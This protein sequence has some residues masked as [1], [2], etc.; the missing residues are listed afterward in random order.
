MHET[1]RPVTSHDID[2]VVGLSLLAWAVVLAV[3]AI[4]P[5]F[6]A[7]WLEECQDPSSAG[8]NGQHRRPRAGSACSAPPSGCRGRMRCA[9][10]SWAASGASARTTASSS[11]SATCGAFRGNTWRTSTETGRTKVWRNAYP[12]RRQHRSRAWRRAARCAR[13]R[14]SVASITPM[15]EQRNAT[16]IDFSASTAVRNLTQP[17]LT[18]L[19]VGEGDRSGRCR[20]RRQPGR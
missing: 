1:I 19:R 15:H 20:P 16:G 5:D 14:S 10:A 17:Y 7:V 8:L 6:L 2:A 11:A 4:R 18:P 3:Y 9:S 12:R 13:S